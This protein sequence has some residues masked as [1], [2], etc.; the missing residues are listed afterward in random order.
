MG[1][2]F[3]LASIFGVCALTF[4]ALDSEPCVGMFCAP[5]ADK[6]EVALKGL[7]VDLLGQTVFGGIRNVNF[8]PLP[9]SSSRKSLAY[10]HNQNGCRTRPYLKRCAVVLGTVHSPLYILNCI[11]FCGKRR[12][13]F[14]ACFWA[15]S[16]PIRIDPLSFSAMNFY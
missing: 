10:T 7:A 2:I 16:A 9:G 8:V 13:V 6:H 12:V 15:V 11:E 1:L 5:D 14:S 4:P 3:S